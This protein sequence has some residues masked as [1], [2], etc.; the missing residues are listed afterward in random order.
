[1]VSIGWLTFFVGMGYGFFRRGRE[2]KMGL[3]KTGV[4]L[5][6]LAGLVF[7]A[8]DLVLGANP[9][10]AAQGIVGWIVWFAILAVIFIVGVFVGDWLEERFR[11]PRR[12]TR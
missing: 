10:G 1:M 2:D 8:I 11:S 7:V 12:V 5:G 9:F 4:L 3:L 6:V